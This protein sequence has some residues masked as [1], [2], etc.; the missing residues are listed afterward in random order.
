VRSE[1]PSVFFEKESGREPEQKSSTIVRF[2][3][4][5]RAF[6]TGAFREPPMNRTSPCG[7][8]TRSGTPY[9]SPAGGPRVRIRLPPAVSHVAKVPDNDLDAISRDRMRVETR[10]HPPR[11]G[12]RASRW[13][14]RSHRPP[15]APSSSSQRRLGSGSTSTPGAW[16]KRRVIRLM[17]RGRGPRQHR[18]SACARDGQDG[19]AKA[20]CGPGSDLLMALVA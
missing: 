4:R 2:P 6:Y 8:G 19:D 12:F 1:R 7:A 9:Q 17:T 15:P 3:A 10:G 16:A 5:H 11:S 14:H 13:R 18:R 20:V